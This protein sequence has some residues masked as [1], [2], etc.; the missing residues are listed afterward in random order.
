LANTAPVP[1][2]CAVL[3]ANY[4]NPFNSTTTIR[5]AIPEKRHV[6]LKLFDLLGREVATL[7]NEVLSVGTYSVRFD[8][9]GLTTG[10]YF[11]KMSAG[12]FRDIKK[13]LV[14]K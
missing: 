6:T 2:E 10:V 13:V 11:I 4:P 1:P 14:L 8:A 5:F 3:Y 12:E 7:K 9:T